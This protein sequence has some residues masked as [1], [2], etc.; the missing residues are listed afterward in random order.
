VGPTHKIPTLDAGGYVELLALILLSNPVS[1][2]LLVWSLNVG[3]RLSGELSKR[4][5]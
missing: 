3:E 5:K 4:R 2:P 1:S